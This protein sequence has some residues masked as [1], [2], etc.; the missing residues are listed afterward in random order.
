MGQNMKMLLEIIIYVFSILG[1]IVSVVTMYRLLLPY[2]K[3]K[4]STVEKGI[5]KLKPQIYGLSAVYHNRM[6]I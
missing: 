5:I 1:G 2:K 3:I 4:W 6:K